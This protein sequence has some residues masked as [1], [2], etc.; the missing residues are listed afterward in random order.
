M[1]DPNIPMLKD[2]KLAPFLGASDWT[3]TPPRL[4]QQIQPARQPGIRRRSPAVIGG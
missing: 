4:A 2:V 1:S 3:I